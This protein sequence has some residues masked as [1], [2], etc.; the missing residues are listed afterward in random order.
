MWCGVLQVMKE[1]EAGSAAF[2]VDIQRP[3]PDLHAVLTATTPDF[4][5]AIM[6]AMGAW[7]V[8]SSLAAAAP[9]QPAM[10]KA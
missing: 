4:V 8:R 5:V 7:S 2:L 6:C 3:Y 10:A 9:Q 1:A